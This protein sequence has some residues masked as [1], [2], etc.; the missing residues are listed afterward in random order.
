MLTLRRF[1]GLCQHRRFGTSLFPPEPQ[2]LRWLD[3]L[4][5]HDAMGEGASH[6]EIASELFGEGRVADDW[7]G[8]SDSLRSRV[9][10]LVQDARVMAAGGYRNMLRRLTV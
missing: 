9:R 2:T 3:M 1:L 4:R 5:V 8:T 6:R 10:R 7:N